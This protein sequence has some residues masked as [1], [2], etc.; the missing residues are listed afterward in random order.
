MIK[1]SLKYLT[2]ATVNLIVLTSLLAFWTDDLELTFNGFV[3]PVEFLKII[4]FT[5][6]SL[7]GMRILVY[8]CRKKN[9]TTV[10]TKLKIAT[11][12]TFLISSYLYV[13]YSSKFINNV[14]VNGQLRKQVADKI[15]PANGMA[16]GTKAENLTIREY[17]E[18]TKVN[19]FP[20]LPN[21]ATNINYDYEYD[22]FL[23]DYIFT[24][25]YDLPKEIKVDTINYE[26]SDFARH[27]TFEII[28]NKK[29]I[30]YTEDVR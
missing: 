27:L 22:G 3:R 16:N 14:V 21:E 12:L 29:R 13:R 6:L 26:N 28:D 20:K 23:P 2:I 25:V 11:L 30:T 9:I 5:T 4:G 15:E 1:K 24:L 17:Q 7:V 19:W 18:I 10:R 8:Y